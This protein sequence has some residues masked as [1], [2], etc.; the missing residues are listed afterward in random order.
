[1][2]FLFSGCEEQELGVEPKADLTIEDLGE[3][4]VG[5][6]FGGTIAEEWNDKRGVIKAPDEFCPVYT[7]VGVPG[8]LEAEDLFPCNLPEQYKIDGLQI[9]FSGY[10]FEIPPNVDICSYA[11]QIT[12]IRIENDN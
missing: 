1:M 5:Y 3:C 6:G 4:K 11:F 9:S 8:L 7:I 2:V 10:L 12:E